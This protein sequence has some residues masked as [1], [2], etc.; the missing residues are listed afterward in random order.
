VALVVHHAADAVVAEA[1]EVRHHVED[2]VVGPGR[3]RGSRLGAVGCRTAARHQL[4][5]PGARSARPRGAQARLATLESRVRELE[6]RHA[7]ADEFVAHDDDLVARV[8]PQPRLVVGHR[9]GVIHEC[10]SDAQIA[11]LSTSSSS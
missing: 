8:V 6:D 4:R 10:T 11:Q 3:R 5:D 9:V 2:T 7:L 1:L